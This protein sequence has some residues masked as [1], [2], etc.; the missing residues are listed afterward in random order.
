MGEGELDPI[1]RTW[2]QRQLQILKT[3]KTPPKTLYKI[4]GVRDSTME[5]LAGISQRLT[6][7]IKVGFY[8]GGKW[9]HC[10]NS[11]NPRNK[12]ILNK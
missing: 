5:S 7:F 10:P 12:L 4:A 2:G 3:K 8:K 6:A 9:S 1:E 11:D